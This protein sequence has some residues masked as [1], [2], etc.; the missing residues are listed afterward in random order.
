M[1]KLAE[2]AP[3]RRRRLS[4][5]QKQNLTGW[6]FLLPAALQEPGRFPHKETQSARQPIFFSISFSSYFQSH[7]FL[8]KALQKLS[9]ITVLFVNCRHIAGDQHGICHIQ[10]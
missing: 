8:L 3:R 5:H 10:K 1:T 7:L 2:N 4:M 9:V 6:A